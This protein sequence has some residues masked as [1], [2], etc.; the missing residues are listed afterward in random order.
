V[1]KKPGKP[2]VTLSRRYDQQSINQAFNQFLGIEDADRRIL[3]RYHNSLIDGGEEFAEIFYAYLQSYPAT[4]GI[5]ERYRER[6]GE[7]AG[8]VRTQLQHLWSFLS[9]NTDT[10]SAERLAHVGEMHQRFGIEPVWVMG[11]Y[12]LYWD[13]LH[14]RTHDSAMVDPGDRTGLEDA[15]TKFLFRDMGLMLEGYWGA[16]M[17]AVE[18]EHH[19]VEELQQQVTSLLA[20]LPQVLWSVDVV[21]NRPLYVSPVTRSIC[22]LDIELP[23]PCLGWTVPEDRETVQRAWQQAL[24][25]EQVEVESRVQAPGESMRWFRRV[26]Q[27]FRDASGRVVRIDGLMEDATDAK[28]TIER[29]HQLATTDSLT[30]L[31]N[32]ALFHDRLDQAIAAARRSSTHRQ[33]VLMLMDLDHFKEI[34][35]TLGHPVGDAVLREVAERLK[36]VLRDS[37]TLARLGGDEFAILLPEAQDGRKTAERVAENILTGCNRPFHHGEH[38]LYFSA[39]IGIAVFPEHGEDIDTLM[40]RA[41]V[42]M[43]AAKHKDT[44]YVFYDSASDPHTPARLQRVAG[45]RRALEKNEFV[46]HYQPQ[47][48]LTH[49]CVIG[50][51]ALLRWNHP[52][53][54][55]LLPEYFLSTAERTGLMNHVTDWVLGEALRQC[56]QWHAAGLPLRVAVNLAA[57]NFQLPDLAERIARQLADASAMPDC[58]E[59]EITENVLMAD[60]EHGSALLRRLHEMGIQ[61]AI[62]DYGTGYSSLAY[63][64]KLPLHKIKIDKSFVSDMARDDNDAVIVRSTIDLAHNLGYRVLAEG[65]ESEEVRDLL[66][67]LGCDCI[68]GYYAGMPMGATQ[69]EEWLRESAWNIGVLA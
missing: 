60:I 65:V 20:N 7:I 48:D 24:A 45:L 50:V 1:S 69:F 46:L 9:G 3:Q 49:H 11:A 44:P 28:L 17:E 19:K 67:I 52:Q 21:N 51:E 26:F 42:A 39:G 59:L 33:V 18:V 10:K 68:Q 34:N 32:R 55:L 36:T 64:K 25:G 23:I 62:D 29:L 31:H 15:L 66:Q 41:D 43:Y 22:N 8:L 38:E 5:L 12:L 4:A 63:L 58:L 47:I 30:G 16:A 40:S 27:P 35:D 13:H 56:R 54:G 61:I 57:R 14:A 6:G 2:K 53:E 37:D